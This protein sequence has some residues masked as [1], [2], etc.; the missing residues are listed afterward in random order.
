MKKRTPTLYRLLLL[1]ALATA[2][3]LRQ[4]ITDGYFS[5]ISGD[6]V[7]YTSWAWQFNEALKE[8]ILY[9]RWTSLNFWGY[10]SP[11]FILYSP[12][13]FYLAA[14][15]NLFTGSLLLAMNLAKFTAL[16]ISAAGMFFLVKE[17][18]SEKTALLTAAFYM[19]LPVNI[20]QYY[21]F[22][23]FAS[24]ISF[25]WFPLILLF[26]IRYLNN[27]KYRHLVYA[28]LCYGGLILTHLIN[29]Y[30]FTFVMVLFI[31]QGCR[32]GNSAR[33]L[34]AIPFIMTTGFL[35]AAGYLLPLAW[36]KRFVNLEA[37]IG[38]IYSDFFILPDLSGK[39][40]PGHVWAV[41]YKTFLLNTAFYVALVLLFFIILRKLPRPAH[42][43]APVNISS[44]A[45]IL[46]ISSIFLLFG[47]S[48]PLWEI[49]P[50]FK[51]IQFPVRWLNIATFAIALLFASCCE[52]WS[53]T[54]KAKGPLLIGSVLFGLCLA[55]DCHYVTNAPR[56]SK[57][58]L[59]P[60][61]P[62]N[63]TFEHLPKGANLDNL[64]KYALSSEK[65]VI[66]KGKGEARI[67][68]WKSA[69]RTL[70][71]TAQEPVTIRLATFNFPGWKAYL[72]GR[73]T[74]IRTEK[75]TG[76]ILVDVPRG[77]NLL[78]FMFEDTPVRWYGKVISLVSVGVIGALLLIL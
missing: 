51:F 7:S 58:E 12:L 73:Q 29:A 64:N 32:G 42:T 35:V 70:Q 15:L 6:T 78:R 50:F 23:G 9:P 41:Y 37:F 60:G 49:I 66:F 30:M 63:W 59:I 43:E 26:I 21:L 20:L 28:G 19:M 39:L 18:Y 45:L 61:K 27:G 24:V 68:A 77:S 40:S 74:D 3:M 53:A 71:V 44:F 72:N 75:E 55:M 16:F 17:F 54:G 10:G 65:A 8:G 25:A 48:T 52:A 31:L 69:E 46:A 5:V 56:F 14:L 62:V 22:G 4:L 34:P 1:L 13:A 33:N 57:R 36:E 38:L 76:A 2:L 67:V 47:I 11:T